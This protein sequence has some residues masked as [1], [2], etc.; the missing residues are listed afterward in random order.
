MRPSEELE[1]PYRTSRLSM[2]DE[3]PLVDEPLAGEVTRACHLLRPEHEYE[4]YS[5]LLSRGIC[6]LVP[7]HECKF[8]S[9]GGSSRGAF[10][11]S[12]TRRTSIV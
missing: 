1:E 11:V 9:K 4:L 2:P 6:V 3:I 8:D 7:L 5:M 12:P 10:F